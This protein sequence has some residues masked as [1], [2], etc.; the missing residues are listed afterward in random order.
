ME[1]PD[2]WISLNW[3]KNHLTQYFGASKI[4]HQGQDS[5]KKRN[6]FEVTKP[7]SQ[8]GEVSKYLDQN[9]GFNR[10]KL[11]IN[12][13]KCYICGLTITQEGGDSKLNPGGHQCE[14]VLTASTIAMLT[15][16]PSKKYNEEYIK[17]IDRLISKSNHTY[18]YETFKQE[19]ETF[20]R[21]VWPLLYD[22]SHPACNAT[23]RDFPFLEIHFKGLGV[24][25]GSIVDNNIK[26]LLGELLFNRK[27]T[28][29]VS[30]TIKKNRKKN[31]SKGIH[32]TGIKISR[33]R[34]EVLPI[35]KLKRLESFA[36]GRYKSLL[37]KI[38]HIQKVLVSYNPEILKS[39]SYL[40]T[41]T[42]LQVVI[43]QSKLLG[44]IKWVE[45]LQKLFETSLNEI[46]TNVNNQSGGNLI[47]T[48]LTDK[49]NKLNINDESH[50]VPN[51]LSEVIIY[52][53]E[54][55][56]SDYIIYKALHVLRITYPD[57]FTT[58]DMDTIMINLNNISTDDI[59]NKINS[60]EY[61]KFI[62]FCI[63]F[64]CYLNSLNAVQY[65]IESI[66]NESINNNYKECIINM[67]DYIWNNW[68]LYKHIEE[69]KITGKGTEF[70]KL[71]NGPQLDS[72]AVQY[73]DEIYY[74]KLMSEIG[75][76]LTDGYVK[77]DEQDNDVDEQDNDVDE[78]DNKL[79][80]DNSEL[81]TMKFKLGGNLIYSNLIRG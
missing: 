30:K 78:Q 33:W 42:M 79:D 58:T 37:T 56:L 59:I 18:E 69:V 46:Q 11:E 35:K 32:R 10:L 34:D 66:K 38:L 45:P 23:K 52:Y 67:I 81:H 62:D 77:K 50:K 70:D 4:G 9:M 41:R 75:D 44:P 25:I 49:M 14:H 15:G 76:I 74:I 39:F 8:C 21:R 71:S 48:N 43:N 55:N 65:S 3:E 5:N 36:I 54:E 57:L 51:I 28:I 29:K 64:R 1:S 12:K 6:C 80:N 60:H 20:Q 73:K 63:F 72:V 61:S 17:I 13:T 7:S 26:K 40:S 24:E 68:S 47:N 19:Y 53:T 27:S 2:K 31:K 16:L 22:W